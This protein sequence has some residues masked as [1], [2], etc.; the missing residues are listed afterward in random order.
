MDISRKYYQSKVEKNLIFFFQ[1]LIWLQKWSDESH[2][3]GENSC[4]LK[5]PCCMN[6][7]LQADEMSKIEMKKPY[8][9]E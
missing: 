3:N 8:C 9:M 5:E 6:K 2:R 4:K 7:L 1:T